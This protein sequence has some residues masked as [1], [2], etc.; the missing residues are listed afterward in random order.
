[1]GV[2]R[3]CT[4]CNCNHNLLKLQPKKKPKPPKKPKGK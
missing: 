3:F 1:M 4:G 2:C